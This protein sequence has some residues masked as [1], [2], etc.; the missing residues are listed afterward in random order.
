MVQ[1]YLFASHQTTGSEWRLVKE[2][3]EGSYRMRL[4]EDLQVV[5]S[6]ELQL[7][8]LHNHLQDC[9]MPDV[10]AAAL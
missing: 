10:I 9:I 5:A 4:M 2:M 6:R 8:A 3:W 1:T 7:N